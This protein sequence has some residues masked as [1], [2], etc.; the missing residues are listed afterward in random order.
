[1]ALAKY[2]LHQL[3][4]SEMCLIPNTK[5]VAVGTTIDLDLN[6]QLHAPTERFIALETTIIEN[7]PVNESFHS[8]S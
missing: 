2:N 1:M 5:D 6:F 7:K 3:E 8:D 4:K